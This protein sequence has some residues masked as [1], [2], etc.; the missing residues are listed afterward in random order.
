MRGIRTKSLAKLLRRE[1][2]G[3]VDWVRMVAGRPRR[4]RDRSVRWCVGFLVAG[5]WAVGM[6]FGQLPG[7]QGANPQPLMPGQGLLQGKLVGGPAGAARVV[8]L[9]GDVSV[10]RDGYPWALQA[11]D[12]V[13]PGQM[14]V[15]GAD[16]YAVLQL[17]DGS[18]FQVFPNSKATFRSNQGNFGDLLDVWLGR[19]KVFLQK[20]GGQ[21]N[22]RRLYTPTA[23]ISVRGTVFEL[24]VEGEDETTVVSVEEGEVEVRHRLIGESKARLVR[25]GET[26]RVYKNVPL[27]KG[28][29]DRGTL[30]E[31]A[32]RAAA[33]AVYTVL[34]ESS[35]S[36]GA[37]KPTG[38]PT[39][40]PSA[41]PGIALPGDTQA[42]VPV[43][44]SLPGSTM[45]GDVGA[46]VPSGP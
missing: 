29:L 35:R 4:G 40:T 26:L 21:P 13:V 14:I 8:R 18:I 25:A 28:R 1:P 15:T 22:V 36:G 19:V 45:P 7:S 23:V 37:I 5:L 17:E 12:F 34:V 43:P 27:A 3:V 32:L 38:V 16:G 30:V 9:E 10:L 20:F 41:G 44:P 42:P 24:G 2:V 31:R 11:G 39:A 33:D 46:P 6:C